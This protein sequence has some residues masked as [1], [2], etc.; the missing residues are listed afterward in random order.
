[1]MAP[2]GLVGAELALWGFALGLP[3]VGAVLALA[4]EAARFASP[5]PRVASR[6]ALVARIA[7]LLAGGSLVL[8]AVV[9]RFPHA[10]NTRLSW[11]PAVVSGLPY[12]T[13]STRGPILNEAS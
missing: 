9:R 8:S 5:S 3:A 10:H 12:A 13:V 4:F 11:L 1:M 7:L 2:R 6:L